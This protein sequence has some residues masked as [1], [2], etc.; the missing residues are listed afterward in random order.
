MT[1]EQILLILFAAL[2]SAAPHWFLPLHRRRFVI[3]DVATWV[4]LGGSLA[5][6][7]ALGVHLAPSLLLAIVV[8]AKLAHFLL[9]CAL[10][11]AGEVRWSPRAAAVFAAAIFLIVGTETLAWPIDGDEP[12]YV[13]IAESILHDRDLDLA[14]QYAHLERS[15]TQR[16][17]LQP[18]PFDPVGPAGEIYARHE[19]FLPLLLVPGVALGGLWG[20]MATIALLG[21][22]AVG[23]IFALTEE[24]GVSRKAALRLWPLLA[25]APPFLFYAVRIWPEVPGALCLSEAMRAAGKRKYGRL[26]AWLVAL[27]L[28]QLRFMAIAAVFA[29]VVVISDRGAR[30]LALALAAVVALPLLGGWLLVGNPLQVHRWSELAPA[31]LWKYA[32][33]MFGLLLDGQAGMLLQAPVWFA[34]LVAALTKAFSVLR[35]P[36]SGANAVPSAQ[37]EPLPRRTE[38]GERRTSHFAIR[39]ASIA[40]VPYL[41]LLLPREEWHGGWSPPLRYLVVFA[42]LV[43]VSA[44]ALLE[45]TRAWLAPVAVWTALLAVHGVAF[46]WRLFHIASGESV[47]GEWL[48][49][50][51]GSDFSRLLPSFIRPNGAAWAAAILLLI[52]IVAFGVVRASRPPRVGDAAL[53]GGRTP[54]PQAAPPR[55]SQLSRSRSSSRR[56]CAPVP[57]FNSKTCTSITARA[58][59]TRRS[60]PSRASA[61]REGGGSAKANRCA[62]ACSRGPRRSTCAR[63]MEGL[64]R[65]TAGSTK[66]RRRATASSNFPLN[67]STNGPRFA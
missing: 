43:A 56:G 10:V 50:R 53:L 30:K 25:F 17:D 22:A 21:A 35:S 36:F 15:A 45:R 28:L 67:V 8:A 57:W 65:S 11:P 59:S 64:S 54:A 31:S 16:L 37:D 63:R 47:L 27:S 58:C 24:H 26:A 66:Y 29:L 38:N 48:S 2:I 5:S 14:N 20:A 41:I 9:W 51:F 6:A 3:S 40:A 55:S 60:G 32:R 19:P 44:G 1:R 49:I 34:A 62:S 39:A 46:P 61:S 42:P 13:L 7:G 4:A 52:A 12:Y 33:G 18:Q 23:S